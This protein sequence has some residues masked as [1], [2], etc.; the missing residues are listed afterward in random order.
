MGVHGQTSNPQ[1]L[2]Y[3]AQ[4]T[5]DERSLLTDV[6]GIEPHQLSKKCTEQRT[7]LK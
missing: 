2:A 7:L 6:I 1:P 3:Q 5:V 4:A